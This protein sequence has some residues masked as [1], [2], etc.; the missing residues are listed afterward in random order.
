MD[1]F[2]SAL[3]GS[4]M[5]IPYTTFRVGGNTSGSVDWRV[6]CAFRRAGA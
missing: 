3:N 6:R 5:S 1:E 4:F 2:A